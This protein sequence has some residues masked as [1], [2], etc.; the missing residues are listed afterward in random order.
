MPVPDF[1]IIGA[2]KCA[3]TTLHRQLALQ[4][5]IC[6]TDKSDE[7]SYFSDDDRYARGWRWYEGL[8]DAAA[9][10]SLRGDAS[11]G[12]TKLPT[13]P[14][15]AERMSR[16]APH[17]R[18]IYLMRHPVD[19]LVSHYIHDWSMRLVSAPIDAAVVSH[20][21]LVE[22]GLY[23][24]QLEPYLARFGKENVLPVFLERLAACPQAELERVC[25]FIGYPGEPLWITDA[26]HAN[27]STERLRRSVCR[28]VLVRTPVL[29]GLRRRLIPAG[30]R[31]RIKRRFTI[32]ERP[33]PSPQVIQRVTARFDE[34]LAELGHQLGVHLSCARFKAVAASGPEWADGHRRA[35]AATG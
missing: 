20:P 22:Y 24:M 15:A 16:D 7:P 1:I 14:R 26:A 18:L 25:R 19:R 4:P 10:G 8:F 32:G 29:R 3:T 6:M 9:P 2:M 28:D 30:V 17:A 11:T 34:D 33:E 13:H 35:E 23:A 31:D 5:G 27:V 12:Y 21:V